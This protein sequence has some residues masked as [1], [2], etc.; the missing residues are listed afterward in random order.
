MYFVCFRF[1]QLCSKVE[2]IGQCS[3]GNQYHRAIYS[4]KKFGKGMLYGCHSPGSSTT[5]YVSVEMG[6]ERAEDLKKG[7]MSS[8]VFTKMQQFGSFTDRSDMKR[9]PEFIDQILIDNDIIKTIRSIARDM[10]ASEFLIKQ[11]VHKDI[12]YFSRQIRKSQFLSQA[13]KD[14]RKDW[15]VKLF[16]KL[17]YNLQLNMFRLFSDEKIFCW[18][19]MIN[20][21]NNCHLVLYPQ[22]LQVLMKSKHSIPIL[23][24]GVV[25]SDGE[26]MP[27]FIFSHGLTQ[28]E[29]PHQVTGGGTQEGGCFKTLRLATEFY[30]TPNKQQNL[31]IVWENFCDHN[32]PNLIGQWRKIFKKSIKLKK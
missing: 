14:K 3:W 15:A 30:I 8:M 22:T 26:I 21:Q 6:G 31:L 4:S 24:F 17:K 7:W 16:N 5:K 9:I 29:G 25:I 11:F 20:S 12:R 13:M 32:T 18:D 27:P 28:H 10:W 23:V 2:T 19:Q 1:C